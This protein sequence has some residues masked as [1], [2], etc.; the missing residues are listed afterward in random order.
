MVAF[1]KNQPNVVANMLSHIG[2]SAIADLLLKII[3]VE[4]VPEGQGIV[5]SLIPSLIGRLDPS[6]EVEVHNTASQTL[7]DII[8]VSYQNLGPIDTIQG[9]NEGVSLSGG[10][11]L[12]DQ[13]KCEAI[14]GKLVSYMLDK[15]AKN[16]ASTLTNGINIIIELI[17]RYCSEIEQAEYQQHQYQSQ[18]PP[19]QRIGPPVPSDEKLCALATDLNDL[20]RILGSHLNEFAD[21]LTSPRNIVCPVG[22]AAEKTDVE[23]MEPTPPPTTDPAQGTSA[24]PIASPANS[25]T[26]SD[27]LSVVTDRF[28][29]SKILPMCLDLF[30][31]YP[32]NNFLHS[33]VYDMIAKVFNT[34][35]FTSTANL[36]PAPSETEPNPPVGLFTPAEERLKRVKDSVYKLVIS[37]LFQGKLTEKITS[38]QRLNDYQVEQPKGVR[39]GYMG[40]LTYISDEVCKLIDK[41]A[42][43]FDGD[44]K[45]LILAEEWQEYLSGVLR[46]T[47][48]RDRQPLGGVRPTQSLQPMNVPLVTGI[49][50]F[51]TSLDDSDIGVISSPKKESNVTGENSDEEDDDVGTGAG[52]AFITDG[53]VTS[54][55]IVNDFPD[56]GILGGDS[57]DEAE[58]EDEEV[59]V[60][61]DW[62]TDLESKP[63]DLR[64]SN[65][66]ANTSSANESLDDSAPIDKGSAHSNGLKALPEISAM[67]PLTVDDVGKGG[68]MVGGSTTTDG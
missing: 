2:T 46:E 68:T 59:E 48:E 52:E 21:L 17:R 14:M 15:G 61:G 18:V 54:D 9:M 10:N 6:L 43:D 42:A 36:R 20:L 23:G 62:I 55:Q 1:V 47:K 3:S 40:H 13:L 8:A 58:G 64:D 38:A 50:A 5:Q 63:T 19:Q 67:S 49:G 56:R 57:S 31:E 51:G 34:Y 27:E 12:V 26:V 53:D 22:T 24:S 25:S 45:D 32:W 30:F 37:I 29:D 7:L 11:M 66:L 4:E 44:I 28:V 41:C 35:S 33:V 39:L 60:E 65:A 16:S